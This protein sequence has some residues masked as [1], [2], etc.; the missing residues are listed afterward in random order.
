MDGG[1]DWLSIL[2][3]MSSL[4]EALQGATLSAFALGF[5]RCISQPDGPLCSI[6]RLPIFMRFSR[7]RQ[8]T[9]E[10]RKSA[11]EGHET[12]IDQVLHH[13]PPAEGCLQLLQNE[14]RVGTSEEKAGALDHAVLNVHQLRNMMTRIMA[15]DGDLHQG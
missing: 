15:E 7:I 1:S 3:F 10:Q 9:R 14:R 8:L 4:D 6:H 5:P 2:Q 13:G 12:C 11:P